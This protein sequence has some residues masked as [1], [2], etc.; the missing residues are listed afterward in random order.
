MVPEIRKYFNANFT[1][2]KY[3]AFLE[4]LHSKHPGAIEFRV[5]ETPVFIDKLFKDKILHKLHSK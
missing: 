5:A 4:D 1:N 3:G 2:E